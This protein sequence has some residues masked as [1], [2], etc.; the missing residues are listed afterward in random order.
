M[1][2]ICCTKSLYV[3]YVLQVYTYI[4]CKKKKNIHYFIVT[5]CTTIDIKCTKNA[6]I[7][8]KKVIQI[9]TKVYNKVHH[10]IK[11]CYTIIIILIIIFQKSAYKPCYI[12]AFLFILFLFASS[13]HIIFKLF[14]PQRVS[15]L[16][17]TI[18]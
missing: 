17:E 18:Y 1:V 5:F 2:K 3:E 12:S 11:S 10:I 14:D 9:F 7:I 13:N 15:S 6:H 16:L 4:L 8:H